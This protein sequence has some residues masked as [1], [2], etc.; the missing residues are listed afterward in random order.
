MALWDK[1]TEEV[2]CRHCGTRHIA[3]YREYLLSNIGSH[4]LGV[5]D[6]GRFC[7]CG[8]LG[9]STNL[10]QIIYQRITRRTFLF[11]KFADLELVNATMPRGLPFVAYKQTM[12]LRGED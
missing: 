6:Q 3:D 10:K 2:T 12:S 11:Q 5:A 4:F 8:P 1:G 7:P 9:I